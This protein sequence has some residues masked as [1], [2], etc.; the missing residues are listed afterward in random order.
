MVYRKLETKIQNQR[1]HS[2]TGS[3]RHTVCGRKKATKLKADGNR[4]IRSIR[5]SFIASMVT[6]DDR[7]IVYLKP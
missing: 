5:S 2:T 3:D 7:I 1:A 4:I 6:T